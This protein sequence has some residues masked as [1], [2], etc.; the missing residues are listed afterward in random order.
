MLLLL[1][2]YSNDCAVQKILPSL[3]RGQ[4][5]TVMLNSFQHLANFNTRHLPPLHLPLHLPLWLDP[6]TSSG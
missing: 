1:D 3:R 4:N 2:M 6:E 5:Y